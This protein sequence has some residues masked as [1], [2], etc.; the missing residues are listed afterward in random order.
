MTLLW[1][2]IVSLSLVGPRYDGWRLKPRLNGR[3]ARLPTL[4]DTSQIVA[5]EMGTQTNNCDR[6]C[7]QTQ[8]RVGRSDGP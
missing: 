7:A 5:W 1:F 8:C 3:R 2:A 4:T 6:H